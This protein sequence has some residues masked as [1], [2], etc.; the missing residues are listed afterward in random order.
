[1]K[2]V[3]RAE[4]VILSER[5]EAIKLEIEIMKKEILYFTD[6]KRARARRAYYRLLKSCGK[7]ICVKRTNLSQEI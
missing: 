4:G 5:N 7:K 2:I 6:K 3:T 1:L